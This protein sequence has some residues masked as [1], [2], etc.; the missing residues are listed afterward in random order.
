MLQ[1]NA[2]AVEH[3]FVRYVEEYVPLRIEFQPT[4][5][6]IDEVYYW[7][8]TNSKYLLELKINATT[9]AV[10]ELGLILVP[11]NWVLLEKS[12]KN[13]C[14]VSIKDQGLPVFNLTPWKNKLTSKEIGIEIKQRYIDES[15]E[16]KFI[17]A[18]DG[19]AIIFDKFTPQYRLVNDGL[20]FCFTSK[21][22]F[23]GIVLENLDGSEIEVLKSLTD[24]G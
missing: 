6:L 9:G 24:T 13:L 12:I 17:I 18:D 11:N 3:H 14:S 1:L 5:T 19:V 16:F 2:V 23:C 7:R 22:E 4:I 20:S 15:Y 21:N 10:A 8:S